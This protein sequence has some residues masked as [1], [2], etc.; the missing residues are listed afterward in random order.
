MPRILIA[1]GFAFVLFAST[2]ASAQTCRDP[3]TPPAE[4]TC[5]CNPDPGDGTLECIPVD[6]SALEDLFASSHPPAAGIDTH[7]HGNTTPE[8]FVPGCEI[9]FEFM[10]R[11][12]GFHNVFGWYNVTGAKPADSTDELFAILDANVHCADVDNRCDT[13]EFNGSGHV[14]TVDIAS[15]PRYQGGEIGFFL[16]TPRAEA[17]GTEPQDCPDNSAAVGNGCGY[18]YFSERKWNDDVNPGGDPSYVPQDDDY[19][20]LLTYNSLV[21]SGFYFAWEDLFAGGDNDFAD[22]VTYVSNIVC[23]G[24]GGACEVPGEEGICAQGTLQCRSGVLECVAQRESRA[25]ECNGLDDDCDGQIDNGDDLCGPTEVCR[26]GQC[27]ERCQGGE[28]SCPIGQTCVSNVCVENACV[29]VECDPGQRCVEGAC[30][31]GCTGVVCP[32]GE[33]CDPIV[34]GCVDP[35]AGLECD[36]NQVC[37]DGVC[38][39]HCS[40]NPQRCETQSLE[41]GGDGRC[42]DPDCVDVSCELGFVCRGGDC[43]DACLDVTCPDGM[44]CHRGQ[45]V[46]DDGTVGPGADGGLGD[47]GDGSGTGG[48]DGCG[49]SVPGAA[50][51]GLPGALGFALLAGFALWR[52]RR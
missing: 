19:I 25:E 48:D 26:F 16:K 33:R 40:C 50:A 2:P 38:Q 20:H 35:C 3:G 8:T 36:G 12:A 47:G 37:V 13:E 9:V 5:L 1:I 52:R 31:D 10:L 18:L 46:E 23:S 15:D 41:C 30:V 6:G 14:A 7:T 22:I 44:V 21:E 32:Q 45:C 29:D 11:A 4:G 24:A 49:C 34:G 28:I 51:G 39:A 42:F 27:I 43:V 17:G